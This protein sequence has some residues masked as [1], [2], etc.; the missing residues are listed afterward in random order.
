M[1]EVVICSVFYEF[2]M[3]YFFSSFYSPYVI[4][5]KVVL[6]IHLKYHTGKPELPTTIINI[7]TS[8]PRGPYLPLSRGGRLVALVG[9]CI[10]WNL[11]PVAS[12]GQSGHK[13]IPHIICPFLYAW[14]K[15]LW[16]RTYSTRDQVPT[17]PIFTRAKI[18][19]RSGIKVKFS[20]HSSKIYLMKIYISEFVLL[21]IDVPDIGLAVRVFANGPGDLGSIPGRVIPKTQKMVLDASLLN[22]IRYGSRVKVEQSRERSSALPYTLV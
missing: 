5:F 17:C 18:K 16:T 4:L 9:V 7:I 22:I 19:P 15:K 13:L 12:G 20:R 1:V 8:Q 14:E 6:L 2:V 21:Y 11:E 10:V 3:S